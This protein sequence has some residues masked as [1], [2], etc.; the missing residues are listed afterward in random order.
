MTAPAPRA[1]RPRPALIAVVAAGGAV[2][3]AAREGLA[4]VV[5]PLGRVP[6]AI[7]LINVVGAFVLGALL[8]ALVRRGPDE[9]RRRL[10]R[11]AVGTGFCGGF[12]TF[13]TLAVATAE[14][15]RAGATGVALGYAV[16]SVVLGAVAAWTGVL[17]GSRS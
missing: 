6:L 9:G 16:G 5:P 8:E 3:T 10:V 2:G 4:L 13:S 11:L 1:P 14:L 12:T 7:L 15:L 17:V